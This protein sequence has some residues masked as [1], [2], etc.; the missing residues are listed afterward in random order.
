VYIVSAVPLGY[1]V[2]TVL[3]ISL[4]SFDRIYKASI[5]EA[6]FHGDEREGARTPV[7]RTVLC[8]PPPACNSIL[9]I[10]AP[11]RHRKLEHDGRLVAIASRKPL[12]KNHDFD[13]LSLLSALLA[14]P[15]F[16]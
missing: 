10:A 16:T 4:R 2:C 9:S 13:E 5:D 6:W 11:D 8:V 14:W 12:L 15:G 7:Y 3:D 1:L